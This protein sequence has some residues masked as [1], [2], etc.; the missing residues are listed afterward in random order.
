MYAYDA[1]FKEKSPDLID[2]D[3]V[4][5]LS[6]KIAKWKPKSPRRIP[7]SGLGPECTFQVGWTDWQ[8]GKSGTTEAVDRILA[9]HEATLQQVKNLRA[10]GM[11]IDDLFIWGGNDA[12]EGVANNYE[13]QTF[14]VELTQRAQLDLA[15]ELQTAGIMSLAPQF[16]TVRYHPSLCNH[17]EW[18]RNGRDR[19]ITSDSDNA[20]GHLADVLQRVFAGRSEFDNVE[21]VI[22]HDEFV[23]VNNLSG[24][25]CGYS[26]GHKTPTA[27]K[28]EEDWLRNQTL[29]LQALQ[30]VSPSIWF[31]AHRH[32]FDVRDLG[33]F[34]KIG[35]PTQDGGS[36]WLLDATGTYSRPGQLTVVVGQH[37]GVGFSDLQM[38]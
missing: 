11:N 26:H 10:K 21:F 9:S 35:H 8:I 29:A 31:T 32:H 15:A 17:G 20:S 23:T 33:I 4:A 2:D 24:I 5:A 1:S 13:S 14:T 16:D 36:K 19:P 18:T 6:T 7:G 37:T 27:P 30:G 22:P 28:A 25:W 3:Q 34:T 12:T 38:V